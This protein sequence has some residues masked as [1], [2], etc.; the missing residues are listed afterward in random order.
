MPDVTV[1]VDVYCTRCG[2]GLCNDTDTRQTH[3]RQQ[4]EFHVKPCE[5]CLEAARAAGY[6]AGREAAE[7]DTPDA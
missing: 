1:N 2:A 5:V 4:W 7:K 3:N 6:D